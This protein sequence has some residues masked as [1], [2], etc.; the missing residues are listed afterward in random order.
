VSYKV[1][2][3]V[4]KSLVKYISDLINTDGEYHVGDGATDLW[5]LATFP[6]ACEYHN[7]SIAVDCNMVLN[8]E[9]YDL[10]CQARHPYNVTLDCFAANDFDA[11]YIGEIITKNLYHDKTIPYRDYNEDIDGNCITSTL[12]SRNITMEDI[13]VVTSGEELEHREQ[14]MFLLD[15]YS[16]Y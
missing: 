3:N 12:Y 16:N 15:F 14:V 13:R 2:H 10:G 11:E 4:E 9:G 6:Y 7:P 5:I 1:I 8:P